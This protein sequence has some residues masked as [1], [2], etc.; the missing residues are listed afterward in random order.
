MLPGQQDKKSASRTVLENF[1]TV[2]KYRTYE[3]GVDYANHTKYVIALF[4]DRN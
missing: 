1:G 4:L 2:G 3:L